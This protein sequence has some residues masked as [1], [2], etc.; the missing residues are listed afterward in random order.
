MNKKS[1]G[2]IFGGIIAGI[3]FIIVGIG[4]LWWN[5]GRTVKTQA[6]INEAEKNYIQVESDTVKI[7]NEGKLISTNGDIDL[8]ESEV[9]VDDSFGISAKTAK[10][11]RKVEMYQWEESCTT[12]SDDKETCTYKKV[13]DEGINDSSDFK[14]S[15]HD[16]PSSAPY[17]TKEYYASNVRVGAFLLPDSLI[18][19]LSTD[20]EKKNEE[21][22]NE[23]T[24][25][26]EGYE[27][28]G[29]YITNVVKKEEPKIG[30]VRISFH[31]NDS[32]SV[33]ILAVQTA[34]TFSEYVT[35]VGT[36]VFRIKE[37]IHTGD[38]IIQDMT[39]ENK[40]MKWLL[41]ALGWVLLM[42]GIGAL[43]SPITKLANFVPILGNV[44]SFATGLIAFVVGTAI[45]LLVIA[46]AWFRY[47]PILSII[48]IL[49]GVALFVLLMTL[50]KK[51][52]TKE[53]SE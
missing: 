23:Y 1:S 42:A 22:V 43:F 10:M 44:V 3:I 35:K 53:V 36:K 38:V 19:K 28:D 47:R 21:L 26:K 8:S 24:D 32:K 31:Y 49:I 30:D 51:K 52:G 17:D 29:N 11:Y 46:I 2:G 27:I 16:N 7:E 33:S 6:G 41:R 37:G 9:I 14:E 25:K 18:E 5:E 45:S 39:N 20:G 4:V 15:G 50:K 13:W 34:D 48:L 12:D 40:M